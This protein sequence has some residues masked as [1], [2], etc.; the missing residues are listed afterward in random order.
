MTIKD[1]P[2]LG[3]GHKRH[4]SAGLS[5]NISFRKKPPLINKKIQEKIMYLTIILSIDIFG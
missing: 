3:L 1:T 2:S 4:F 5:G